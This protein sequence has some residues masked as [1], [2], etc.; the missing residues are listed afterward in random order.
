MTTSLPS[1]L[2]EY[3]KFHPEA[4]GLVQHVGRRTWDLILLDHTGSWVRGE[5]PSEEAATRACRRLKVRMASGWDDP[6]MTRWMNARDHW[7]TP[8]G[9]R[10]AL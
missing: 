2:Y 4:E 9:Q 10:R 6:R 5:F 3:A 8:G 1:G 7:N